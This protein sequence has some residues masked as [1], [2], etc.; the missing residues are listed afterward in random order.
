LAILPGLMHLDH[1]CRKHAVEI[2]LELPERPDLHRNEPGREGGRKN[3]R[4]NHPPAGVNFPDHRNLKLDLIPVIQRRRHGE[5][6]SRA[7]LAG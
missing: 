5:A 2:P 6:N 4:D 3:D 7:F 1:Q